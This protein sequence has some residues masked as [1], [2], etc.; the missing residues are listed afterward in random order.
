MRDVKALSFI[1]EGEM[2][3][4][5]ICEGCGLIYGCH[6]ID[7]NM[8]SNR[9]CDCNYCSVSPTSNKIEEGRCDDCLWEIIKTCAIYARRNY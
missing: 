4:F 3:Y 1:K 9:T 8:Q 2:K 6:F 5:M 7:G